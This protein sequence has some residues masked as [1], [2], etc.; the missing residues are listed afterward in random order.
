MINK[1]KLHI[2]RNTDEDPSILIDDDTSRNAYSYPLPFYEAS[3]ENTPLI[4]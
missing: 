3:L 1:E 4:E 2:Q